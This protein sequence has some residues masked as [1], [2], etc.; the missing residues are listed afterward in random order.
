MLKKIIWDLRVYQSIYM[1][2]LASVEKC[3]V[4]S[5]T[6]F[7][8]QRWG[9]A[10]F[11][12]SHPRFIR[13][14]SVTV[15]FLKTLDATFILP[16]DSCVLFRWENVKRKIDDLIFTSS[17]W[18]MKDV[19]VTRVVWKWVLCHMRPSQVRSCPAMIWSYQAAYDI[20][21]ILAWCGSLVFLLS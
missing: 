18:L 10:V 13:R 7:Y 20:R 11:W 15:S 6:L 1:F 14:I 12:I 19:N 9:N 8:I 3:Y 21:S 2:P 5:C 17:V 4:L 16:A